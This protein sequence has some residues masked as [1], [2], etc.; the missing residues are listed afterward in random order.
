MASGNERWSAFRV[1]AGNIATLI[2]ALPKSVYNT[3]KRAVMRDW[4]HD[5]AA[6]SAAEERRAEI[7]GGLPMGYTLIYE[8]KD[9]KLCLYQDKEGHLVAA[10]ATK[11]V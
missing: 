7:E 1:T 5:A 11:L 4:R 6:E 8:S 10:D 2:G 9:G 3:V